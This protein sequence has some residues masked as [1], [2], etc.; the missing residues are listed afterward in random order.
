M[1]QH[2]GHGPT[3]PSDNN[4][5]PLIEL[6]LVKA[7]QSLVKLP[8]LQSGADSGSST[9]QKLAVWQITRHQGLTRHTG[10]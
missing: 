2:I 3:R 6:T 8:L 10:C 9:W 1:L 4:T 5:R 7:G